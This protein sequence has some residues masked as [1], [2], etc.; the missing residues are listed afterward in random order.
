MSLKFSVS[1]LLIHL[2]FYSLNCAQFLQ[3]YSKI[4]FEALTI[5]PYASSLFKTFSEGPHIYIQGFHQSHL[6]PACIAKHC[7]NALQNLFGANLAQVYFIVF[8]IFPQICH[9]WKS[10]MQ[11]PFIIAI[12]KLPYFAYYECSECHQLH[13]LHSG[14]DN[15]RVRKLQ[16][17]VLIN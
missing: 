13:S 8:Q 15:T 6:Y 16:K 10:V 2:K 7:Q 4:N 12:P 5:A 9:F 3:K 14:E 11:I 17:S 1:A